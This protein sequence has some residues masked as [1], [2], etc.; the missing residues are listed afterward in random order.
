MKALIMINILFIILFSL[1]LYLDIEVIKYNKFHEDNYTY[2]III[3]EEI[4]N[5]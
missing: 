2:N 4:Q 1:I 5:D 3:E